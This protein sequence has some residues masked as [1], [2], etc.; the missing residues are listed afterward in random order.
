MKTELKTDITIRQL[1]EGFVYNEYDEKGLFGLN[2][3]LVIQPDYQ[4]NYIYDKDNKDVEVVKSLLNG[5][6]LG[7]LYFVRTAEGKYEVLD[8]QQRITSFGR[9][10][11]HTYPFSVPDS[12]GDP[13][14]FD[15][16][17][18]EE[19]NIIL[20]TPLTIY[21]CEGTA[22][23]IQEWFEKINIVGAPLTAQ[24]L[25][26]AAYNGSFVTAARK[27][28]SNSANANMHK[29]QAYIKG[30]TKR[31]EILERALDW[32][33]DGNID[34]Y[35]SEHRNDENIDELKNH[36]D[37]VID[38]VSHTFKYVGKE[39]KGLPWGE[40]YNK[41]HNNSYDVNE[42][43]KKVNQL[44]SDPFVTNKRGIF[45][46]LLSGE[47]MTQLLN[48][49]VFDDN[50]K[51]IV[52]GRQTSEATAEDK[53]NCPL[54]AIGHTANAKRIYA[55]NEMDADH[56]SAWMNGGK[57]DEENCQMLCITHNRAKGNK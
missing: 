39:V 18:E 5:Y 28:F 30:D 53:S 1:C 36:F 46:Y 57:T 47:E 22:K 43:D 31:Q 37:S 40:L 26:N 29:Y 6:P 38:W 20:N 27:I 55:L 48:V 23:E 13:R 25:R 54:C 35:M 49:R 50:T 12:S 15:S 9:F 11:N 19:R 42:L 16:L 32:V 51:R 33:S 2:G 24:E 3:R 14:Y 8:G 52:Y 34:E 45:E 41:Y 4:R 7:L 56:V 21:I 44:L 10:V 17:S